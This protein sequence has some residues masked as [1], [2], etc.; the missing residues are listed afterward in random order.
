MP[1]TFR[2]NI[3]LLKHAYLV[4]NHLQGLTLCFKHPLSPC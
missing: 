4:L 1:W 2:R 3:A